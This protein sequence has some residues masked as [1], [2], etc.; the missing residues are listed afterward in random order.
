MSYEFL[1]IK[2]V[3]Q[4][5]FTITLLKS[6]NH[7]LTSLL[8]TD[9]TEVDILFAKF[10]KATPILKKHAKLANG[11]SDSIQTCFELKSAN[12]LPT[13]NSTHVILKLAISLPT[14]ILPCM[15][16]I[17]SEVGKPNANYE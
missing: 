6:A 12:R 2:A 11:L 1:K 13:M 10:A 3:A 14:S 16:K 7:L 17:K 5:L 8:F 4:I 9:Y 15:D